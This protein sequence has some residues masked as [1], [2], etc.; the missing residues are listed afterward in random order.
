[1]AY[2]VRF[3]KSAKAELEELLGT[4]GQSFTDG[5]RLWFAEIAKRA[6]P[7]NASNPSDLDEYVD[8]AERLTEVFGEDLRGLFQK[9]KNQKLVDKLKALVALAKNRRPPWTLCYERQ[10]VVALERV[11]VCVEVFYEINDVEKIVVITQI[12][13]PQSDC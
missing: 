3:R 6:E 1:M 4:Y 12:V 8:V 9:W 7:G 2:G 13:G 11:L 10:H 5:L